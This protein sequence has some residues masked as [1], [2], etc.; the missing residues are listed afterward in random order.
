MKQRI[1]IVHNGYQ[2]SGGESL[3]AQNEAA[4]L[5]AH[6]H[7]VA[8]Y[9]RDNAE[10]AAYGLL[11]KLLLPFTTLF[12]LRTCREVQRLIAQEQIDLVHVHNTVPLISPAVYYAAWSRGVPVVQTVH[13]YRFVCPNGMFYR[14]GQVCEE[15]VKHGLGRAVRHG[16][17]R[18]S[19]A[20]S[21]VLAA[22]LGLHRLLGTYRRIDAY[23]CLTSFARQKLMQKLP[24]ERLEIK[25]N[26]VDSAADPLPYAAHGGEFVFLGRLDA[27]KGVWVLLAAFAM[28]PECELRVIGG[29]PEEA[30]MRAYLKEHSM[31]NVVMMG[32][33]P[34]DEALAY[35]ARARAAVMPTQWYEG[36]PLTVLESFALGTPVV[37]S[38]LGNVGAVL[39]EH[40]GGFQFD[41]NDPAALAGCIAALTQARLQAA[42]AEALA[43]ACAICDQEKNYRMLIQIYQKAAGRR[44]RAY[45]PCEE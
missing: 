2:Q 26:I 16:C 45:E 17:Y 14:D 29:G 37:G 31:K 7:F 11:R 33:L 8:F 1:L 32:Q 18:G 34:H 22:A 21:L 40:G 5:R 4:M 41:Q 13:N 12:S 15:C 24:R 6:G 28:L 43:A 9:T 3:V 23:I 20:Q 38:Q 44:G 25:P 19:R 30:A 36:L 39:S 35:V 10:I 27:Q 42:S